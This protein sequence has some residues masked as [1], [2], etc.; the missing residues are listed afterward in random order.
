[1]NMDFATIIPTLEET[2][3]IQAAAV[4]EIIQKILAMASFQIREQAERN[5][6]QCCVNLY[7]RCE[8]LSRGEINKIQN[9]LR[10]M[11]YMTQ[12]ANP[13]LI[14]SWSKKDV[15]DLQEMKDNNVCWKC[16]PEES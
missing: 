16:L 4:D 7:P 1:M 9:F 10:E 6:N 14:I 13:D 5:L 8:Y 11:G 12:W 3:A 15:A 2:R